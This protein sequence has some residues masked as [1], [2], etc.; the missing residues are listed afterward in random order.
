MKSRILLLSLLLSS[1]ITVS[2]SFNTEVVHP[3]RGSKLLG[4]INQQALSSESFSTWFVKNKEAYTP[5]ATVVSAL[6]PV[7]KEY[8]IEAYMG[9]W[10][11]DSKREVPRFYK[12]LEAAGFPLDRLTLIAVDN[13]RAHYKQSPGGEHEGKTIHR[14]P[15]F[16]IK[17]DGVEHNRIVESPVSTLEEDL[18]A[19]IENTY[20]P[21]HAIVQE[22]SKLLSNY[23]PAKFAKKSKRI[24]RDLKPLAQNL[25]Q[26]NTYSNVLFYDGRVDSALAIGN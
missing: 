3:E 4:K 26:L 15:T 25:Y 18:L 12:T 21:N 10:C 9:T 24:A 20:V 7:L 22:A 23:G 17:K 11:G 6:A 2:Q 8:T 16:I 5:Q 14:V 13:N 1:F 19:I